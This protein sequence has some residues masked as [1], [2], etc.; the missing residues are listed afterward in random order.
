VTKAEGHC[1]TNMT[2]MNNKAVIRHP[3]AQW[4]NKNTEKTTTQAETLMPGVWAK[5]GST[6]GSNGLKTMA[7][8][9]ANTLVWR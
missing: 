8:F 6:S 4:L 3:C 1:A 9:A 5:H 7:E 2:Q